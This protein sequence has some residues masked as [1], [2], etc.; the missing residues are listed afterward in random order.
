MTVEYGVVQVPQ[1]WAAVAGTELGL[2]AL[3]LPKP[4][5][6]DA[7]AAILAEVPDARPHEGSLAGILRRLER[8]FS[9]ESVAFSDEVDLG[10]ATAFRQMVWRAAREIP[11]GETRTYG[12]LAAHI[13]RPRSARAVGQALG[14]NPIPLVIP[15]HRV[16][17]TAGD[18]RGF[19]DGLEMKSLLLSLES[20]GSKA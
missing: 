12:W 1:G 15:C 3:V 16:V 18:L 10:T 20:T 13:G 8:Y 7:E 6:E 19:A 2:R 17:G 5:R 14:S 9:G 11:W 4:R